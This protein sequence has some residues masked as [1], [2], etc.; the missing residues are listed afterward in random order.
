S[1]CSAD[2]RPDPGNASVSPCAST[3]W[4]HLYRRLR[5]MPSSRHN[6]AIG[7]LPARICRT[8]S[9]LNSAVNCCRLTIEH[10]RGHCPLYQVSELPGPLQVHFSPRETGIKVDF[11]HHGEK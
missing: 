10:L 7:L 4:F 9:R 1:L 8:A 3:A 2:R 11:P 6:C 5:G